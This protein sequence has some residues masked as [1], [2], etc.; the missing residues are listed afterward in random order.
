MYIPNHNLVTDKKEIIEFISQ[1]NFAAIVSA[2]DNVPS[3]THLPFVI[4][5]EAG[6]IVLYSHYAKA[7]K[8]WQDIKDNKVLVI[9]AEPHAY[10]SPK[11]YGH[12]QNVPTWNYAAVHIYGTA[13]LIES[14]EGA[15]DVLERSIDFFEPAYKEQWEKLDEKFKLGMIN[16]IAAFKIKVT[17]IQAK[18]KL[19]QNRSEE[20]RQLIIESFSKSDNPNEREIAEHMKH[21][22]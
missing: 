3:A 7:N 18:K 9:F 6:E 10:I 5:E 21:L 2:K 19:S 16:G 11:Y 1:Y 17:D 22:K 8:Q 4:T 14:V 20:E 13:E 12:Q 15:I